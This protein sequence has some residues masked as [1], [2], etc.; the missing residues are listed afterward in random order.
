MEGKSFVGPF[1]EKDIKIPSPRLPERKQASGNLRVFLWFI[2]SNPQGD[3]IL[4]WLT[5][6]G[7]RTV[8]E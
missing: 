4:D 8:P 5:E 3:C 2:A 7:D 6:R 1:Q